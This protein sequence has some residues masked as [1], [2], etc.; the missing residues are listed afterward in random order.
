MLQ[1]P[2]LLE[3]AAFSL[4]IVFY[5]V[6]SNRTPWLEPAAHLT[7]PNAQTTQRSSLLGLR[8]EHKAASHV[9]RPQ[10][11][12]RM[13]SGIDLPASFVPVFCSSASLAVARHSGRI[14]YL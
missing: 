4:R 14:E 13:R 6:N 1:K 9:S 12:R 8:M 2:P 11:N 7:V 5:L 10:K 3:P